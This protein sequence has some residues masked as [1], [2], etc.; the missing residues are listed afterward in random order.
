MR[1]S[2]RSRIQFAGGS[3][4]WGERPEGRILEVAIVTG[5]NVRTSR[6]RRLS[7]P[8]GAAIA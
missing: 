4:G 3:N 5:L 6:P 7:L 2:A 8:A 1:S